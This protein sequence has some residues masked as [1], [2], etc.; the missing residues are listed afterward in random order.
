[1]K[2]QID[3]DKKVL[4][5]ESDVNLKEFMTKIKVLFPDG[6]WKDYTLETN[7]EI[8]WSNP[9]YIDRWHYPYPWCPN[10]EIWYSTDDNT[11][12]SLAEAK[13]GD[14]CH[15]VAA[16]PDEVYDAWKDNQNGVYCVEA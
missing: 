9:I 4:R 3:T 1:M 15:T 5:L 10:R 7:V 11:I 8:N 14:S 12:Y 2:I 13:I 6:Q 16:L